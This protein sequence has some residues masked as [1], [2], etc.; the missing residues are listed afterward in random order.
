MRTT[1]RSKRKSASNYASLPAPSRFKNNEIV[2]NIEPRGRGLSCTT[3]NISTMLWQQCIQKIDSHNWYRIIPNDE[4]NCDDLAFAI[5]QDWKLVLPLLI[6]IG[7]IFE[8]SKCLQ[9]RLLAIQ[10]FIQQYENII[11]I[12]DYHPKHKTK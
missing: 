12:A 3:G 4:Q 7:F 2:N 8:G 1:R 5:G 6:D 9:L 10:N 11:Q